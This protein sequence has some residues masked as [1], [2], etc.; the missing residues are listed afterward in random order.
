MAITVRE[1]GHI[2]ASGQA[3]GLDRQVVSLLDFEFL[4]SIAIQPAPLIDAFRLTAH[5]G[6]EVIQAQN[7]VGVVTLPSGDQ[8]EIVPKTTLGVESVEEGRLVLLKMLSTVAK[9][10]FRESGLAALETLHRSWLE[11]LINYVLKAIAKVVRAGLR[12]AYVR[13]QAERPFLRGQLHVVAQLRQRPG[14]QHKF[15]ISFDEYSTTRPENRLLRSTVEQLSS[16]SQDTENQRLSRELLFVM[17]E[18]PRSEDISSDLKNWSQARDMVQYKPLL[19]WVRFVL[20]NQSPIFSEGKWEGISLLFPMEQ[21]FE[22]YVAE[23][24]KRKIASPYRLK[25]QVRTEYLVTH[26]DKPMFQLRPDLVILDSAT[27]IAVLDTKWKLINAAQ[28]DTSKKYG[29]SQADFYQLFAYGEKYLGG[30]GEL[31]LIYPRHS[32]FREPLEHFA[33][34]EELKLWSVPFDMQTDRIFWPDDCD[35]PFLSKNSEGVAA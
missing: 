3:T 21:L 34:T 2:S 30:S 23:T 18:I 35:F 33:F 26:R 25:S 28:D 4:K 19:P 1:F 20:T 17:D 9:L 15:H 16:W 29:L 27:P 14:R 24:L 32:A 6:H 8:L 22:E 5:S 12:K 11:G 10:E 13:V 31:F 7:F